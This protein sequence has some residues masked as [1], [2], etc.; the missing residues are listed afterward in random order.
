MSAPDYS[1]WRI[2]QR[3]GTGTLTEAFVA[4]GP[5]SPAVLKRLLPFYADNELL[6][7]AFI[8]RGEELK[9]LEH[10]AI[11]RVYATGTAGRD[12]YLVVEQAEGR[13]LSRVFS[14][15]EQ[16]EW[17]ALPQ[18]PV[19]ACAYQAAKA[20]AHAHSKGV[21]HLD[22]TLHNLYLAPSGH[23]RIGDFGLA[24]ARRSY[25]PDA[26]AVELVPPELLLV[27]A[28]P[29][30]RVDIWQLAASTYMLLAGGLPPHALTRGFPPLSERLENVD[31]NLNALLMR[32]LSAIPAERPLAMAELVA[33]LG[34][35]LDRA[36]VT[37]AAAAAKTLYRNVFADEP[38]ED[39]WSIPTVRPWPDAEGTPHKVF[40][41]GESTPTSPKAVAP[42]STRKRARYLVGAFVVALGLGAAFFYALATFPWHG[43]HAESI[44]AV[45]VVAPVQTPKVAK[46][47]E[48]P[49]PDEPVRKLPLSSSTLP[50]EFVV[51]SERHAFFLEERE[52]LVIPISTNDAQLVVTAPSQ[53]PLV[54][55]SGPRGY[56]SRFEPSPGV[57]ATVIPRKGL[58][59]VV[60]VTGRFA[61]PPD[62]REVRVGFFHDRAAQ[63]MGTT[64]RIALYDHLSSVSPSFEGKG[65]GSGLIHLADDERFTLFGLDPREPYSM[66]VKGE[67]W[68]DGLVV[69]AQATANVDI[70]GVPVVEGASLGGA[71]QYLLKP[72]RYTVRNAAGL[73]FTLPRTSGVGEARYTVRVERLPEYG[74]RAS[75]EFLR[76]EKRKEMERKFW[77]AE[78]RRPPFFADDV[79]GR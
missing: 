43:S 14:R 37:D 34:N 42:M 29:D 18:V 31:E 19:V 73:L 23:V 79:D 70:L 39:T 44:Q 27:G 71:G 46:A 13:A 50:A 54:A 22:V 74:P 30:P 65:Q 66:E 33:A 28:K 4:E 3:L 15:M 64:P 62:T 78:D 36:G 21:L 7:A 45:T 16:K 63:S 35:W 76:E 67:G 5:K 17:Q 56:S 69:V 57:F 11:L 47:V 24:H 72:G 20:L 77:E 32:S 6:S 48:A 58:R 55:T 60:Y 41:A 2:A 10:P 12:R 26:G 38:A 52:S 53:L 61:V 8:L 40:G 49:P 1:P 59:R 9:A 51:S 25:A 75:E 68:H